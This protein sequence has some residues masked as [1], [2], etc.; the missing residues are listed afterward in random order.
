MKGMLMSRIATLFRWRDRLFRIHVVTGLAA[1][2]WFLLMALT[3]VLINHQ[4]SFG[5]LDAAGS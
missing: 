1:A 3:G 5:L 2:V 4:E